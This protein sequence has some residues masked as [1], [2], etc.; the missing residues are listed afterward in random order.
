MNAFTHG[1]W[2]RIRVVAR[3]EYRRALE[4]RWLFGFTALFAVL[5]LGLSYFGLAQGREVGFQ[6]FARVT[7][8][9][10]N[11]V[12]LI[13][14]LTGLMLGITSIAGSSETLALLLA[15]PVTRGEVLLGRF[16][17]LAA[18]LS[19]AQA[20]GFGG[21]GVV[22]ALNAGFG[23]IPGFLALTALSLV[24][25]WLTVAAALCI[26]SIWPDRL[27]AMSIGLL[28][29]LGL[30]VAYDLG[31]L[32]TTALLRGA[33]LQAVLFPALLLNPVDLVRILVTLAVGSGALF[34]PT[35]AVLAGMFGS[36]AGIA[37]GVTVLA[38]E[39]VL[40]LAIAT[41]VFSRRDW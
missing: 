16:L 18:A 38:L 19:A 5:V 9:L 6:G 39:T 35:S 27:Q 31:V 23:Q 12:L 30:V 40:P 11:L 37:V 25:G 15:Q 26:A 1:A 14:P 17:G 3:E 34:G 32:G 21:G 4:T 36:H 41:R 20:L 8:S 22:I 24:L 7:L 10:M 29:W 28:L 13:V 33:P 2:R